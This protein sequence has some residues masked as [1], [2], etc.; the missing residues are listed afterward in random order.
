MNKCRMKIGLKLFETY[1]V[2]TV[3]FGA[4][5]WVKLKEKEMKALNN[6][7]TQ[8]LT[9]VM[10]IPRTTPKCALLHATSQIKMEHRINRRKLEYY[11]ELNNREE[12][13]NEVKMKQHCEETGK[14]YAT[15][16]NELKNKYNITEHI[17]DLQ[18][19][20]ALELVKDKI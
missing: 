19:K 10:K 5:S 8:F 17:E 3:L 11:I 9:K 20:I 1:V 15:E 16:I 13:R 12:E 4:E 7:Q 6:I 14:L 2:P 18:R